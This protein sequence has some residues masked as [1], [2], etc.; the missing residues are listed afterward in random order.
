[1]R[2]VA[3]GGLIAGVALHAIAGALQPAYS[4]IDTGISALSADGSEVWPIQV[5][6]FLLTA[7][8]LAALARVVATGTGPVR[9]PWVPTVLGLAAVATVAT[10]AIRCSRI[11]C[12][13]AVFEASEP[14]DIWHW[15]FALPLMVLWVAAPGIA[16]RTADAE[17]RWYRP[18]SI[19]LL[20]FALGAVVGCYVVWRPFAVEPRPEGL[21]QRLVLGPG[22]VWFL[23]TAWITRPAMPPPASDPRTAGAALATPAS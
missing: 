10:A 5:A 7:V 19:G 3:V 6:G 18:L 1:M 23:V 20:L 21:W 2:A 17:P 8:G 16:A 12:P 22:L 14:A 4:H 11:P 15:S 9:G 13:T